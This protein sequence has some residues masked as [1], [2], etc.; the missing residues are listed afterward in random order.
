M[1]ITVIEGSPHLKGA[2]S[3][4]AKSFIEGAEEA[5][6]TVEVVEVARL[7]IGGCRACEACGRSGPC[8]QSDDMADVRSKVMSSD[9]IAFVTPVYFCGFTAQLKTVIDRFY[10]FSANLK[11]RNA[12]AVLIASSADSEDWTMD[13]VRLQYDAPCR[14]LNLRDMGRVLAMGCSSAN[15][16]SVSPGAQEAHDLGK[17]L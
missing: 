4:L 6:H 16:A 11:T 3:T 9:V 15:A 13:A 10:S 14:Y 2:S 8:I 1:Q 17:G 5:G 12:G 7:K